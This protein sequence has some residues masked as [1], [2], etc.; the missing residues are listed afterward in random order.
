[1]QPAAVLF[2]AIKHMSGSGGVNRDAVAE[3]DRGEQIDLGGSAQSHAGRLQSTPKH[4]RQ[5][6]L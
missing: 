1:M 3:E 2:H 6:F 4:P 5:E